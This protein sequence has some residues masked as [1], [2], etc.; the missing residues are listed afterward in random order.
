M[1]KVKRVVNEK[2]R[3]DPRLDR[4]NPQKVTGLCF[5]KVSRKSPRASA[6]PGRREGENQAVT[7]RRESP[8]AKGRAGVW[9][10]GV[11]K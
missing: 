10:V 1:R 9:R 3:S 4:C 6:V 8:K 2:R 5:E 7:P 11:G